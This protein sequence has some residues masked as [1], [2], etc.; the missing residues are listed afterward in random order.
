MVGRFPRQDGAVSFDLDAYLDRIGYHG[1]VEPTSE[2]LAD[3]HLAHVSSIPFENLDILLGRPIRLDLQSLQA[4]LVTGRR[5]GYCFEHNT[6]F[7]AVLEEI[8]FG[9]TRLAARVRFGAREITAR[10]HMVLRVEADGRAW[11]AD[12]GFGGGSILHPLPFEPG[13]V[14]DQ[15]G[16]S[17]R[18]S[19]DDGARVL[20]ARR[21]DGWIDFYAFTLEPQHPID[22]EVANHYTSTHPSSSFTRTLTAQISGTE[23]SLILRD[24]TLFEETPSSQTASVVAD[25]DLL[26]VLAVRFTL[27]FPPGTRFV[28][29]NA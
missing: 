12:V 7:A 1:R 21:P 14:V 27:E 17:F 23:R 13:P 26:D 16:W 15:F 3:L 8:G 2:V 20:E 19:D 22:Y 4:K 6:L 11:L 10:T 18:L 24:R 28:A 5:G 9:V 25:E 29:P